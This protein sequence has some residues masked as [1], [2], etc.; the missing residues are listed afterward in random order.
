MEALAQTAKS[1]AVKADSVLFALAPPTK[2]YFADFFNPALF[3]SVPLRW[4]DPSGVTPRQWRDALFDLK[5]SVLVTG[6]GTPALPES[7]ASSK[8]LSLRYVCHL[9][10]GVKSIIPRRILERGLLVSNWGQAIS[11]TIAEHAVLLVLGLLR[12][13]PEWS[14]FM[15]NWQQS[16]HTFPTRTLSTRSLLGKRVG[17][18]GFGAIARDIVQMLRP[19]QVKLSA[20]SRGVP[21]QL[22]EEFQVRQ[23][24]SLEELF[25]T[26]DI[27][28]ECEA[29]T[30]LSTASVNEHI[31][32]LLPDHAIFVNVGRA[33][34]V[35]EA[36]LIRIALEGKLRIGLDVHHQEPI[37]PNHPLLNLRNVL[38]SPHIAGPTEDGM[39]VLCE[40][41]LNNLRRYIRGDEIEARV[42]MEIYDRST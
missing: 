17:I 29:L 9:A 21:N 13:V 34:V 1:N 11:H 23:T 3:P 28:I 31:L 18:H 15:D 10:G 32:R 33:A 39:P 27:L 26:S 19:F 8:D 25:A 4:L 41:A 36:A 7:Y 5:P 6:W 42:S 14:G 38:L 2:N 22:F 24:S 37:S 12:N 30:A 40:F 20:Y 16:S 35:H